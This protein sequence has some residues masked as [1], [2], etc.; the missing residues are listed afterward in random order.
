M[1]VFIR[2]KDG[3]VNALGIYDI[4]TGSLTVLKGSMVSDDIAHSEKF[5]GAYSIEKR[6][7]AYVT[8]RKLMQ[9]INFKSPS[10]ASNFVTG[11]STNGYSVWKVSAKQSLGDYLKEMGLR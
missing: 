6:R 10:T 2:K 3:S 8:E 7:Q 5:R 11:R 9:D 4:E 1:E